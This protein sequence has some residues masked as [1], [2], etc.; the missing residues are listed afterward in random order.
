MISM[1]RRVAT[2]SGFAGLGG[3]ADPGKNRGQLGNGEAAEGGL[4]RVAVVIFVERG[5]R[6]R[7]PLP[8]LRIGI[9]RRGPDQSRM[10]DAG[11]RPPRPSA[12]LSVIM[13]S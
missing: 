12:Q 2:G 5:K 10:S 13:P 3:P 1:L 8:D 9:D 6:R 11:C 4:A 7:Q